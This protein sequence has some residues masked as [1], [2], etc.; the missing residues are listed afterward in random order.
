M[1]KYPIFI[2]A[3][4]AFLINTN[5]DKLNRDVVNTNYNISTPF[6]VTDNSHLRDTVYTF[7]SHY[8]DVNLATQT[9]FLHSKDGSVKVFGISSGTSKLI[10]GVETNEGLF[11]IHA[12]LPKWYSHQFDS[13]LM[14]NFMTFNNGIGFHALASKGYYRYL[15]VKQSSHGCLRVSR[16]DAKEVFDL[17]DIGTPVLVH[18]GNSSIAIEFAN[19]SFNYVHLNYNYLKTELLER[20][21]ELYKGKYLLSVKDKLL[22]D[23]QNVWQSGLPIGNSKLISEKQYVIKYNFALIES[24]S[25]ILNITRL[26]TLNSLRNFAAR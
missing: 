2:L 8:I 13:T 11:V 9:A 21:Q 16:E 24:D 1:I 17:V 6:L 10:D 26:K 19:P 14:L 3:F 12:M 25:D 15:G 23:R 18:S 5:F 20:S 22:I 7:E 4:S